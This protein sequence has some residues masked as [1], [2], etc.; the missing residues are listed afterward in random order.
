MIKKALVALLL[1]LMVSN[2]LAFAQTS[3]RTVLPETR[4]TNNFRCT[5]IMKEF[6]NIEQFADLPQ[7]LGTIARFEAAREA[8]NQKVEANEINGLQGVGALS[9]DDILGC[10]IITGRISLTYL[11][12]FIFYILNWLSIASGVVAM[13]FIIIGGYK[14]IVGGL[15]ENKDEGK[16]TITN[17]IVGLLVSTSA[18]I[19]VNIVQAFVSS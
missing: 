16:K 14:Y 7:E 19:I 11:S 18:W 5:I 4:I 2:Q 9:Q 17:A 13:I 8:L 15:S 6:R 10:S 12:L 1:S 3:T